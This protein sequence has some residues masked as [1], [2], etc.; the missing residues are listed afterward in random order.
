[1]KLNKKKFITILLAA[2]VLVGV[3]ACDPAERDRQKL[4]EEGRLAKICNDNGGK[5]V[6]KQPSGYV[7]ESYWCIYNPKDQ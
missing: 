3:S 7:A 4:I 2:S 6:L 5:Y 1:M